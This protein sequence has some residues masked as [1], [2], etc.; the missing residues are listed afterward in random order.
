VGQLISVTNPL[1]QKTSY[2]YDGSNN[3]STVTYG[4]ETTT[5]Q[6]VDHRRA[7]PDFPWPPLGE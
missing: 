7:R 5:S 1:G 4:Y 6:Q 2:T 3:L